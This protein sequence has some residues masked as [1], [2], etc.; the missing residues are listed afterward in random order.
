MTCPSS[1]PVI[2]SSFF[3][4]IK[5]MLLN[6]YFNNL[7]KPLILSFSLRMPVN[8]YWPMLGTKTFSLTHYLY[9][10]LQENERQDDVHIIISTTDT[11]P[12]P[13][14]RL[15]DS[16]VD[17]VCTSDLSFLHHSVA[18]TDQVILIKFIY[19]GDVFDFL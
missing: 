8:L 18:V 19:S 15:T 4:R 14:F 10:Y 16:F 1:L 11:T 9:I 2:F 5:R 3:Q 13:F 12:I 17:W 6:S 7:P